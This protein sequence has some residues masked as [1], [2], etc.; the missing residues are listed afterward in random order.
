MTPKFVVFE[1]THV[2][3]VLGED[4]TS[5]ASRNIVDVLMQRTLKQLETIP[6]KDKRAELHNVFI[7]DIQGEKKLLRE[8]S[9]QKDATEV[10]KKVTNVVWYLDGRADIINDTSKKRKHVTPIP[11]RFSK[12]QGFQRWKEWK[13][14]PRLDNSTCKLHADALIQAVEK[15]V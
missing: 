2:S 12:Y 13:K 1:I 4:G 6:N 11:E 14:T 5:S 10:M 9:S 8:T 15:D 3:N 7:R